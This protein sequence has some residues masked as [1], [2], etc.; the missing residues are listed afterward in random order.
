[1]NPVVCFKTGFLKIPEVGENALSLPKHRMKI[2]S[3]AFRKSV[4]LT[5]KTTL[6]IYPVTRVHLYLL[7]ALI[8]EQ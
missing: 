6:Q 7:W 8:Q 1:M 2:I 3:C 4:N 5:Y